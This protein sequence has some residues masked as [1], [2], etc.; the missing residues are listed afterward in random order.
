MLWRGVLVKWYATRKDAPHRVDAEQKTR[1]TPLAMAYHNGL[2]QA[3]AGRSP[4]R[5]S[6]ALAGS[7]SDSAR[8]DTV[9]LQRRRPGV[10][11]NTQRRPFWVA[12][13]DRRSATGPVRRPH[14]V[15]RSLPTRRL[16][17]CCC[18]LPLR[19]PCA[20]SALRVCQL[21]CRQAIAAGMP[22]GLSGGGICFPF[23]PKVHNQPPTINTTAEA[24]K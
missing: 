21:L 9:G 18:P 15:E 12:A 6:W 8:S 22:V 13:V 17:L 4:L 14:V 10:K 5:R 24:P 2:Q 23:P 7:Q 11:T 1:Q 16:A 19:V 20:V 3:A